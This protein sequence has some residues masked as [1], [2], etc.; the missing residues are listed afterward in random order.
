MCVPL[1]LDIFFLLMLMLL[2]LLSLS[3]KK[4]KGFKNVYYVYLKCMADM[5]TR[6]VSHF[7]VWFK[8]IQLTIHA[9]TTIT[10]IFLTWSSSWTSWEEEAFFK[11]SLG[12]TSSVALSCVLCLNIGSFQTFSNKK[13]T[14]LTIQMLNACR[15]RCRY[16]CCCCCYFY[17][18]FFLLLFSWQNK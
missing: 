14:T 18:H 5:K 17:F 6:I 9:T 11:T 13:K 15:C 10:P 12:G 2:P 16:C 4:L 7:F 1:F 3:K 8:T